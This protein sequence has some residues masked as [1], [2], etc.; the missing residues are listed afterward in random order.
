MPSARCVV[1]ETFGE[2]VSTQT[3]P[4]DDPAPGAMVVAV[5]YGGVCGTALALTSTL[6]PALTNVPAMW[7]STA[8]VIVTV[9]CELPTSMPPMLTPVVS[10][11]PSGLSPAATWMF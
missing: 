6:P 8:G 11:W 5:E 7:A 9:D 1:L 2:P 3:V 4:L 10:A